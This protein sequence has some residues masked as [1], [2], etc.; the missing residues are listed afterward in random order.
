MATPISSACR[1]M[2]SFSFRGGAPDHHRARYGRRVELN[3]VVAIMFC[4]VF[5]GT[6]TVVAVTAAEEP[7]PIVEALLYAPL[8]LLPI[9]AVYVI[10]IAPALSEGARRCDSPQESCPDV[11]FAGR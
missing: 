3:T 1:L 5:A 6:L 2:P 8:V 10:A 11:P 7:L 4:V 9:A